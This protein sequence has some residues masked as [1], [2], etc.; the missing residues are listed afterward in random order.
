V[1][2]PSL[3]T[4]LG[5][6]AAL[7]LVL[8]FMAVLVLPRIIDG[9]MI[10]RR[11]ITDLTH[12]LAVNLSIGKAEVLW[13]PQ[14]SIVF[15]K[16]EISFEDHDRISIQAVKVYPSLLN[17]L[18]ARVVM[19][20]VLV[21]EPKFALLLPDESEKNFDLEALEQKIGS[22]LVGFTAE[23][24]VPRITLSNG[25]L[26]LRRGDKPPIVF[27]NLEAQAMVS[28]RELNVALSAR[29]NISETLKIEAK[30]LP[31]NFVSELSIGVHRLRL[32]EALALIPSSTVVPLREGN[33]TFEVKIAATGLR[34]IQIE[35]RG[36]TGDMILTRHQSTATVKVDRFLGSMTYG[37]GAFE[38]VVKRLDLASPRLQVSGRVSNHAGSVVASLKARDGD[39]A[40]L[41]SLASSMF[42]DAEEVKKIL[43]HVHAGKI[44]EIAVENTGRTLTDLVLS[45]SLVASASLRNCNI[46]VP[47][48]ELQ[49]TGVDGAIR[50]TDGVLEAKEIAANLGTAKAWNGTL[51][52]G[53][54]TKPLLFHLDIWID[55]EAAELQRVL[56]KVLHD[57]SFR[58][59]LLKL[60]SVEGELSGRLILGDSIDALSPIVKISKADIRATYEP[61]PFPIAIRRGQLNYQG[62]IASLEDV[63][64]SVGDSN[65]SGLAMTFH[66]DGSHQ[67]K[68]NS[69]RALVD[70]QQTETLLRAFDATR[71]SIEKVRSMRGQIEFQ[72]F[73][74]GGSYNDPAGWIYVSTGTFRQ[75]DFRQVNFP[76]R[77]VVSRGKFEATPKE[78][79]FFDAVAARQFSPA[80]K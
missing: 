33:A 20:R 68:L 63:A 69:N 10:K 53:L 56:L 78:I 51:K 5:V 16:V 70:L 55:S 22:A 4:A 9:E 3:R 73:E 76:D 43:Q 39:I 48:T 32:S 2:V 54:A 75:A 79:K 26:E 77:I 21:V 29:S 40:E 12:R 60:R 72:N 13:F 28:T 66:R 38:I 17:L 41:R 52:L 35:V 11:I 25:S 8:G 64:G 50:F 58:R 27:E 6:L 47:A 19:H 46:S 57:E 14:P 23:I 34:K 61:V 18:L 67:F 30:V 37:E 42:G 7:A 24:P 15:N 62:K 65:F 45:K 1:K 44:S 80:N 74:L 31:G 49:L 59:E 71:T 36:S